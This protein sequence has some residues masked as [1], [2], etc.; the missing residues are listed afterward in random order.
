M[1]RGYSKISST[2]LVEK[3][4]LPLDHYT[5]LYACVYSLLYARVY[6]L[7]YACVYILIIMDTPAHV[8]AGAQKTWNRKILLFI[9][10][11]I[12]VNNIRPMK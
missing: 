10:K 4:W 9:C 12:I 1:S 11:Y 6:S 7:L 2:L 8:N 3:R 5:L